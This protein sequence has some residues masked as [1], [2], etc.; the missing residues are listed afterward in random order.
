MPPTNSNHR[1]GE[2]LHQPNPDKKSKNPYSKSKTEALDSFR[3]AALHDWGRLKVNGTI[4]N[5]IIQLNYLTVLSVKEIQELWRKH[6]RRLR[7]R[8]IVAAATIEI[9]KYK[10]SQR[11]TK[12]VHYQFV[13]KDDRTKDELEELFEAICKCEMDQS[14]FKIGVRKFDERLGGWKEYIAYFVKLRNKNGKKN[15]LFKRRLRLR[16]SFVINKKKWWTYRDGITPRTLTSIKKEMQ[17]YK[18]IK[19]R[20]KEAERFIRI[21]FPP[22]KRERPTNHS[23]LKQILD[24]EPDR[25]LYDWYSTLL[26]LPT[27]FLTMPPRWLRFRIQGQHRQLDDLLDAIEYR[28]QITDSLEV[29][30]ALQIY[31]KW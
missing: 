29:Y 6:S 30:Y 24:K 12:K 27:V 26:G 31:H 19:D 14:D 8:G 11:A 18:I 22:L 20:L 13:V 9:T 17:R 10:R 7:N 23:K 16:K 4:P 25:V 3:R 28:L 1:K 5:H 21:E 15:H 2:M